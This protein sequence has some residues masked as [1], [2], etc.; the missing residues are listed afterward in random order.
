M[1]VRASQDNKREKQTKEDGHED[2]IGPQRANEIDQTQEAHE[3][4]EEAWII[5][6]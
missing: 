5:M 4:E 6:T 3:E 2:E 1:P